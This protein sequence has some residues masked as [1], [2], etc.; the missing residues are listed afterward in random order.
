MPPDNASYMYV[1]YAVAFAVYALYAL[2]IWRRR[3][4]VQERL[5]RVERADAA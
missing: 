2:S 1:A 3:R 4:G 5:R